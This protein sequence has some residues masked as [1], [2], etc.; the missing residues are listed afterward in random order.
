MTLT[1]DATWQDGVLKPNEPVRL[2]DGALVRV[3][4]FLPDDEAD[5]LADVIGIADGPASGDSADEHDRYIYG[6]R[7]P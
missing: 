1:V 4:I 2:P 5:P 6:E 3:S 7:L